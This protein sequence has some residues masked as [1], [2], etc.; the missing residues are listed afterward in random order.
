MNLF[1]S[2]EVKAFGKKM[3]AHHNDW[4]QGGYTFKHKS[5]MEIWTS[6]GVLFIDTYP[7]TNA[8]NLFEK[9]YINRCRRKAARKNLLNL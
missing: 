8:F 9:F 2:K 7:N 4:R 3:V 1:I 5:G 6:N